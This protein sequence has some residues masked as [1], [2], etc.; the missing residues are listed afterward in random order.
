MW[1]LPYGG[2]SP[3]LRTVSSKSP[4]SGDGEGE[5]EEDELLIRP[6]SGQAPIPSS[7]EGLV[8]AEAG[9]TLMHR[10]QTRPGRPSSLGGGEVGGESHRGL[11]FTV[12]RPEEDRRPSGT[13]SPLGA[14]EKGPC[15]GHSA[16]SPETSTR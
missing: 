1:D 9:N 16:R 12:P 3:P 8:R 11:R 15:L 4:G 10:S 13:P 6:G 7:A 5:A 14:W 2:C